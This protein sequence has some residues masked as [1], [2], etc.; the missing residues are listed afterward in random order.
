MV[1]VERA[2]PAAALRERR[3]GDQ[4]QHAGAA[5]HALPHGD[6]ADAKLHAHILDLCV[7]RERLEA[8]LAAVAA[9]LVAAERQ[10]DAAAC[11]VR[12]D[13]RPGRT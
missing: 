10:L 6:H 9:F 3:D 13:V 12:V 4:Q 8:F 5:E 7:A 2:E 1:H 11:A